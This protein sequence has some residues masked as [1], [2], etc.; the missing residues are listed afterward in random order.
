MYYHDNRD[1]YASYVT[2]I[3]G[4]SMH[5]VTLTVRLSMLDKL[6]WQQGI[7]ALHYHDHLTA[8]VAMVAG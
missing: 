3:T 8:Y 2:M 6:P 5:H 1:I 4:L 7:H